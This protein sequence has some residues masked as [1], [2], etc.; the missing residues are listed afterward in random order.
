MKKVVEIDE[1]MVKQIMYFMNVVDNHYVLDDCDGVR[2]LVRAMADKFPGI[3]FSS[4]NLKPVQTV[5]H[6]DAEAIRRQQL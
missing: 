2:N 6:E 4:M 1:E 5:L 3:V